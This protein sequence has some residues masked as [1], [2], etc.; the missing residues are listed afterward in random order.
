MAELPAAHASCTHYL[1][2]RDL[3]LQRL[4]PLHV[5]PQHTSACVL[6]AQLS[7]DAAGGL[8]AAAL[9]N[10]AFGCGSA[11]W[12]FVLFWGLNGLLQV[13][14]CTGT[15]SCVKAAVLTW[16]R[17]QPHRQPLVKASASPWSEGQPQWQSK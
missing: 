9:V 17:A 11:L 8:A 15:L 12:W 1:P 13:S 3:Q 14:A 2:P 5:Q 7:S 16:T 10:V 4:C 6:R